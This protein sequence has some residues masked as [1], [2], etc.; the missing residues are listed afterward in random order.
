MTL[1]ARA[2][3][4]TMLGKEAAL[5]LAHSALVVTLIR[6]EIDRFGT[7]TT[8]TLPHGAMA[9]AIRAESKAAIA[10]IDLPV[11][12]ASDGAHTNL[13]CSM[14]PFSPV[15]RFTAGLPEANAR[16]HLNE[17]RFEKLAKPTRR[18]GPAPGHAVID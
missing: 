7:V 12:T 4:Y 13:V 8:E 14:R 17:I 3:L 16:T 11:G 15:L 10:A 5:A 9:D 6:A 1:P 2:V 18:W